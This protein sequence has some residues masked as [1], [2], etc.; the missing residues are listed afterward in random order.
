[1][2]EVYQVHITRCF[3]QLITMYEIL[4]KF[5]KNR[6]YCDDGLYITHV[7]SDLFVII[8]HIHNVQNTQLSS[9]ACDIIRKCNIN[10]RLPAICNKKSSRQSTIQRIETRNTFR[11]IEACMSV[12][13]IIHR[14]PQKRCDF[15]FIFL[16]ACWG[17]CGGKDI[18]GSFS[19]RLIAGEQNTLTS[20]TLTLQ[21]LYCLNRRYTSL[22]GTGSG[23]LTLRLFPDYLVNLHITHIF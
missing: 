16:T 17:P 13:L 11:N 14:L 15:L 4:E 1:M 3:S 22:R 18:T 6:L 19:L 2:C 12:T 20:E 21:K 10:K 8:P 7:I 23:G 9:P 5:R